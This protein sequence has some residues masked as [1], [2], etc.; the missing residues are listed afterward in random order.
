MHEQLF[1]IAL[2]KC[3]YG[4]I[5]FR[6]D[7][8]SVAH[9]LHSGS[10]CQGIDKFMGS[11]NCNNLMEGVHLWVEFTH[12]R[13]IIS[14]NKYYFDTGGGGLAP[15]LKYCDPS[16]YFNWINI[17]LHHHNYILFKEDSHHRGFY[18]VPHKL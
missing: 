10:S 15:I 3:D 18:M 13:I 16:N 2:G 4:C 17:S 9:G 8:G 1:R 7:K 6:Q 5:L 12:V 14:L 11:V